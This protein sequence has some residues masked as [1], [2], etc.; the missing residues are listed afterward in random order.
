VRRLVEA[1][2]GGEIV[3]DFADVACV[4][5]SGLASD[6]RGGG[7]STGEDIGG[8]EFYRRPQFALVTFSYRS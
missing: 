8:A 5:S 4:Q 1:G 3:A 7:L 2:C 6:Q